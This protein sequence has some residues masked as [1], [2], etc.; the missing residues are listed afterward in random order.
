MRAIKRVR[1]YFWRSIFF[2]PD[3][4]VGTGIAPVL[5]ALADFTAGRESHPAPKTVF[6][7]I[8]YSI[9]Y[10]GMS[11]GKVLYIHIIPN[12]QNTV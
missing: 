12:R 10:H 7:C 8:K 4:T 9:I 6:I 11:I 5:L 2:H 3:Y 1:I